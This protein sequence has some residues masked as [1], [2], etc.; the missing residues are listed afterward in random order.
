MDEQAELFTV[1]EL[2]PKISTFEEKNLNVYCLQFFEPGRSKVVCLTD[3]AST[4]L[5]EQ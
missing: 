1:S 2:H 5:L 4:I 3:M